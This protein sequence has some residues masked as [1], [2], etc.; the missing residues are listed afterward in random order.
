MQALELTST[1]V[2]E[3]RNEIEK[4]MW[5]KA[6]VQATYQASVCLSLHTNT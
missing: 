5:M 4:A 1:L 3:F 6:L 2:I